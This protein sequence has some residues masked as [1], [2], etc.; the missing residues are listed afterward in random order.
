VLLLLGNAALIGAAVG[1]LAVGAH[2][3]YE[4]RKA[5]RAASQ[6]ARVSVEPHYQRA[7]C[8]SAGVALICV[9]ALIVALK[10]KHPVSFVAWLLCVA[11][12]L[13]GELYLANRS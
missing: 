2:F 7:R 1:L 8:A 3:H 13:Y 12:F 10:T 4:Y 9:V 11:L 6:G 5:H